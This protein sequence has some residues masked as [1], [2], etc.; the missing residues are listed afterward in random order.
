[1]QLCPRSDSSISQWR[2]EFNGELSS[3]ICSDVAFS[4]SNIC[5]NSRGLVIKREQFEKKNGTY[6]FDFISNERTFSLQIRFGKLT[7]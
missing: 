7:L 5:V 4:S 3:T 1:M 2:I 6:N